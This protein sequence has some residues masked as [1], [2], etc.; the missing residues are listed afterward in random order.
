MPVR[1]QTQPEQTP[2]GVDSGSAMI[3]VVERSFVLHDVDRDKDLPIRV[4]YPDRFSQE[5]RIPTIIFSHGAGGS[6]E[7]Y[8]PLA[9][10]WATHGYI[11]ILPTHSDSVTAKQSGDEEGS[12]RDRLK[13][14]RSRNKDSRGLA[15]GIDLS[16]WANRPKDISFIIDSLDLIE[17]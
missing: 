4:V 17:N 16:D 15:G 3:H 5:G 13:N 10:E 6:G 8:S 9:F 14:R 1:A 7:M 12:I 2:A 11:V